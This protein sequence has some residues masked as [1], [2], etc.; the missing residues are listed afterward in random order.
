MEIQKEK[1]LKKTPKYKKTFERESVRLW[2]EFFV[3]MT[4]L[5]FSIYKFNYQKLSLDISN[6]YNHFWIFWIVLQIIISYFILKFMKLVL[7]WIFTK[8]RDYFVEFYEI[9]YEIRKYWDWWNKSNQ[10]LAIDIFLKIWDTIKLIRRKFKTLKWITLEDNWKNYS[11]FADSYAEKQIADLL[12]LNWIKYKM[13]PTLFLWNERLISD[14]YLI[15][16][17]I[18]IE[19][20]GLKNDKYIKKMNHKIDLYRK[21]WLKLIMFS[22]ND[23]TNLL[24]SFKN[25]Y[26]NISWEKIL[27]HI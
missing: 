12:F 27:L 21:S 19:F 24:E 23:M 26:Y 8:I 5:W 25:Q 22:G 2:I 11:E 14:F 7:D 1:I 15:D 16:K 18:Y 20:F 17:N 13:H 10:L 3:L 4:L 6:I 9:E